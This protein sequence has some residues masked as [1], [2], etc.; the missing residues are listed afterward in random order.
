M[1][2]VLDPAQFFAG[3]PQIFFQI[4]SRENSIRVLEILYLHCKS[5]IRRQNRTYPVHKI[6]RAF[7]LCYEC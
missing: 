2:W 7:W 3:I 6:S 1:N 5:R 4:F